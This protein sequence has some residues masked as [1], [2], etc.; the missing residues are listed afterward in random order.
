[1]NKKPYLQSATDE[2]PHFFP[3]LYSIHFYCSIRRNNTHHH[4][5]NRGDRQL[6]KHCLKIQKSF[7]IIASTATILFSSFTIPTAFA[8]PGGPGSPFPFAPYMIQ[9]GSLVYLFVDGIF[10]RS[11]PKG[12][13]RTPA[14]L[15]AVIHTLPPPATTIKVDEKVFYTYSEIYYQ[16]VPEGYVVVD[17]PIPSA[18]Q[19]KNNN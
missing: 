10:L 13:F 15:G 16:K 19:P 8:V 6:A 4:V 11:G 5:Q 9:V 18:I 12:Y 17:K 1:M 3:F 14:P 7:I 2:F